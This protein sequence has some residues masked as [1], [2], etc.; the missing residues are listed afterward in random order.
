MYFIQN[1]LVNEYNEFK[2]LFKENKSNSFIILNRMNYNKFKSI[3][4]YTIK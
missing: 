4:E 1:C 3:A 2:N